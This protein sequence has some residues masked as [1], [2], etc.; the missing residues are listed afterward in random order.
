MAKISKWPI[1]VY[2]AFF[3][4]GFVAGIVS[5]LQSKAHPQPLPAQVGNAVPMHLTIAA[6]LIIAIVGGYF[7]S[8]RRPQVKGAANGAPHGYAGFW[9]APFT[10]YYWKRLL[11]SAV[12]L[13]CTLAELL[14]N[15]IGQSAAAK[16]L[17]R[18][19]L[20]RI[21]GNNS[22]AYRL[23]VAYFLI[24]L[25]IAAAITLCAFL[26]VFLVWR[27]GLEVVGALDPTFTVGAW[28]GPTYLGASFAHYMDAFIMFYGAVVVIRWLVSVQLRMAAQTK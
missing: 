15:A 24:G 8:K 9:K 5:Y 7:I 16:R 20:R 1:G 19:R 21:L 6:L 11:F 12:S 18:W 25:P 27:A 23:S 22:S 4:V 14:L 3:A 17:E 26:S 10:V 13:P 28:G 2:G